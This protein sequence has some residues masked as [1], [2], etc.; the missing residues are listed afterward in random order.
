MT[1]MTTAAPIGEGATDVSVLA[2]FAYQSQA[3]P[4]TQTRTPDN[5]IVTSQTVSQG[6]ALPQFEAN[7]QHGVSK[8]LA[9]NFHASAAGLQPGLKITLTNSNRFAFALLPA[10]GMG[11]GSVAGKTFVAG[12][13][14]RGVEQNPTTNTSFIFLAGLK[15]LFWQESGFYVALGYDFLVNRSLT[16]VIVP[17]ATGSDQTNTLTTALSQNFGGSVG[18]EFKLG[19]VRLRPE[20]A[21]QFAPVVASSV[22]TRINNMETSVSLPSGSAWAILPGL[23]IGA[24]TPSRPHS[25]DDEEDSESMSS[26][27]GEDDSGATEAPKKNKYSDGS[28]EPGSQRRRGND[29]ELS[30]TPK[31]RD[32]VPERMF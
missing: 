22:S 2:G 30:P 3:N 5:D 24:V 21:V 9:L 6:F 10:L 18:F 20:I 27:G 17:S 25:D 23:S 29:D 12:P 8:K 11:Y 19:P 1:T 4:P 7:L 15:V 31:K 14:G 13:D 28:D 32:A 16:S 26:D